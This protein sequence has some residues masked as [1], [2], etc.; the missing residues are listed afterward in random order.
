MLHNLDLRRVARRSFA[1]FVVTLLLAVPAVVVAS[2]QFPDVPTDHPFHGDITWMADNGIA[3]GFDDGTYRPS[4]AVTR[5]AM[6]AFMR[7]LNGEFE[8]VEVTFPSEVGEPDTS[9]TLSAPCPD[10]KR[11]IA[12]GGR[13]SAF[14]LMITDSY[15]DPGYWTVRWESEDDAMVDPTLTVWALCAPPL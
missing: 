6:A 13:S 1:P 9:F 3:Q 2:H 11:A 5:Q 7:R 10:N 15:P 4:N 12:G 8:V 14:E